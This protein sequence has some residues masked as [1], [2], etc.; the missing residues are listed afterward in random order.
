MEVLTGYDLARKVLYHQRGG[1]EALLKLSGGAESDW[2]ELKAGMCLLPED[3]KHGKTEKDLYWNIA[4]AVIGIMNTSG[5]IL[6]IGI[7]DGTL[8]AVPLGANDPRHTIEKDG[9]EAYRRKEILARLWPKSGTWKTGNGTWSIDTDSIPADQI[10]VV[11]CRYRGEEIA[12][13][14]IKPAPECILAVKEENGSQIDHLFIR[15]RGDVGEARA[16]TRVGEIN[17]YMKEHAA[18]RESFGALYEQFL[19]ESESASGAAEID[20]RIAEYYESFAKQVMEKQHFALSHFTPLD[21][22]ERKIEADSEDGFLSPEEIDFFEEDW[23]DCGDEENDGENVCPAAFD[24]DGNG[25]ADDGGMRSG[26][27]LELMQGILRMAILGEPGGGKTTTLIN[28]T[29]RFRDEDPG[30]R[31]LAVFIPMGQWRKGGSIAALLTKITGLSPAQLSSLIG[32]GRLRL[33]VDAVNEC[34][35]QFRKAAVLDIKNFL[36]EYPEVPVAIS[37]RSGRDVKSFRLPVFAILPMDE[38]HRKLYLAKYLN[39]ESQAGEIMRH[40]EKLPGGAEIAANPMLLRMVTEAIGDDGELP[41]GRAALYRKWLDNWYKRESGKHRSAG[42]PLPW[43]AEETLEI[44]SVL[45]FES[46]LRG[47]REVPR[48]TAAEILR[49]CGDEFLDKLCQ[50]PVVTVDG[51]FV[52]FL[53]ETFQEYLCAEHLLRHPDSV[54]ALTPRDYARWGM[55]VAYASEL[56]PKLPEP[57]LHAAWRMNSWF[58]CALVGDPEHLDIAPA[59]SPAPAAPGEFFKRLL[60]GGKADAAAPP[61]D[62]WYSRS[63]RNLAYLLATD[64]RAQSC[65]RRLELCRLCGDQEACE[66]LC[67]TMAL[68]D[69]SETFSWEDSKEYVISL[70]EKENAE[71]PALERLTASFRPPDTA[72]RGMLLVKNGWATGEDFIGWGKIWAKPADRTGGETLTAPAGE[73]CCRLYMPVEK[74]GTLAKTVTHSVSATHSTAHAENAKGAPKSAGGILAGA[75]VGAACGMALG[76]IFGAVIGGTIGAGAKLASNAKRDGGDDLSIPAD[77]PA[78][79]AGEISRWFRKMSMPELAQKLVDSGLATD[80]DLAAERSGWIKNV[81]TP[82]LAKKYIDLGWATKEDFTD[83]ISAWISGAEPETA[84][85]LFDLGWA[86]KKDFADKI[87][88]W[89]K[90]A[91]LKKVKLLLDL[92]WINVEGMEPWQAK[93][94]I[95]EASMR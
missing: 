85:I 44:F 27:L 32:E 55:A 57:L 31:S 51:D 3:K 52:R 1:V 61:P 5:G 62:G 49:D 64:H 80:K 75:G 88:E 33:V 17:R 19:A 58:G 59:H 95:D 18:G 47:Y 63:D 13:V 7:Q 29:L 46:R 72:I 40:L 21:A 90:S 67:D 34:P 20:R 81:H 77:P 45:A 10:E 12:A 76:G 22:A 4:K 68:K 14:L 73:L 39:D 74:T 82:G 30:K 38:A 15:T 56:C 91:D 35:D 70:A 8:D 86:T 43:T 89:L 16:M 84:K 92:G 26:D 78:T 66:T 6:L 54:P 23:N 9:P 24:G 2:L 71:D 41:A 48:E 42:D 65:W 37:A 36:R 60:P 94:M 87:P 83:K 25:P 28:F 79:L 93:I 50:G 53:H 11:G 69:D